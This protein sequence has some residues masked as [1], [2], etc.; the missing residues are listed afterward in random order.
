MSTA[1]L[2]VA[3][4]LQNRVVGALG[5]A[6]N[7]LPPPEYNSALLQA[8]AVGVATQVLGQLK[9]GQEKLTELTTNIAT[10]LKEQL[11][12]AEEQQRRE[13]DKSGQLTDPNTGLTMPVIQDNVESS[14]ESGGFNLGNLLS[15]GL[16]A[17][18]GA[19][20]VIASGA[21]A[22]F[23]KGLGKGLVKG[24]FYGLL[25]SFLAK[26]AIDF[27]EEGILKYD[28]PDSEE[29]KMEQAIISAVALAGIFGPKGALIG[30]LGF[31]LKGIY[32]VL[33]D[34]E[35]GVKDLT[36]TE[37]ASLAVG[38]IG[39]GIV[40]GPSIM[41]GLKS[42]GFNT[43]RMAKLGGLI[44]APPF[45]IA[46]GI[47][48]AAGAGAKLLVD[49]MNDIEQTTL[50]HLSRL[51]KLTQEEF[52]T[53]LKNQEAGFLEKSAPG[54]QAMIS[55]GDSLTT[56]GQ[57][58]LGTKAALDD[59]NETGQVDVE[60][61]P[62]IMAMAEKYSRLSQKDLMDIMMSKQ[63]LDDLLTVANNLR[64][65]ALK[66]GLG[67]DSK[68]VAEDMLKLGDKIKRAAG[69]LIDRG[70]TQGH[71]RQQLGIIERGELGLTSRFGSV[72]ILEKVGTAEQKLF[73]LNE[74][75]VKA[76]ADFDLKKANLAKLEDADASRE[77]IKAA[78]KELKLA[79]IL[80]RDIGDE[81]TQTRVKQSNLF[82][83]LDIKYEDLEKIFSPTELKELIKSNMMTGAQQIDKAMK[84]FREI[85]SKATIV[86]APV[87][88]DVNTTSRISSVNQTLNGATNHHMD[89]HLDSR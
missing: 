13:R 12:I 86:N 50:D 24:G 34:P 87:S 57:N 3:T 6:Q 41:K 31:G 4:T 44:A 43:A 89:Q 68:A 2:G 11:T 28:I 25:A 72:D 73:N 56:A 20:G 26:P 69:T 9:E 42:V 83:S 84:D 15:G 37:I 49:K 85:E 55:G 40:F 80:V 18:F 63:G 60:Q 33:T 27:L 70:V 81:I 47:A 19:G 77:E 51:M 54:I 35:K 76:Q 65:I 52:E 48:L 38:S 61:K 78:K 21:A 22:R 75:L 16:G 53:E 39:T 58:V 88:T 67:N 74:D 59:I 66:G 45:I 17:I 36:K 5:S 82:T 14:L 71:L 29:E 32:D 1:A 64:T 30:L 46:G 23:A 8:G 7:L 79:K 10:I 62:I